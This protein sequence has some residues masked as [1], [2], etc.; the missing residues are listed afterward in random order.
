MEDSADLKLFDS[1]Q[2]VP[3]AKDYERCPAPCLGDSMLMRA[4]SIAS[5]LMAMSLPAMGAYAQTL[6]PGA[7]AK[8]QAQAMSKSKRTAQT[9]ARKSGGRNSDAAYEDC[10]DSCVS[11]AECDASSYSWL[12]AVWSEVANGYCLAAWAAGCR[13]GCSSLKP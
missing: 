7:K 2:C 9:R 11:E 5:L 4:I 3:R 8:I 10:Y 13:D 1:R 6:P 12:D